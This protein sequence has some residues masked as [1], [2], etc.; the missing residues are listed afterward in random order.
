MTI[1]EATTASADAAPVRYL[2]PR[3]RVY[4]PTTAGQRQS[5]ES[6]SVMKP[7]TPAFGL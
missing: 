4:R 2:A 1:P 7:R 3:Q 6:P 5:G